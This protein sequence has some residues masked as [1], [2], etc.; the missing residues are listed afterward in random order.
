MTTETELKFQIPPAAL[1]AVRQAVAQH[2]RVQHTRL[3]ARYFDTPDG[4]LARA[5]VALRLRLEG[6]TWVQ[7]LK[8]PAAL[9]GA[10]GGLVSRLEHEVDL[11]PGDT[12]PTLDIS[13]H[14]DHPAGAALRAALHETGPPQRPAAALQV[15]FETDVQRSHGLL[16]HDGAQVEVALDEG[17]V[18]AGGRS[19]PLCELELELKQGDTAAL[20]ALAVPWVRAH[21]LWLDTRTKA[22]RGTLL[23]QA[24]AARPP[25]ARRRLAAQ[26]GAAAH[27]RWWGWWQVALASLLPQASAVAGGCGDRGHVLQLR[28]DL[29]RLLQCGAA[30]PSLAASR[31]CLLPVLRQVQH[32]CAPPDAGA[33]GGAG[34]ADGSH[35]E[36][37]ALGDVLRQPATT[38]LWLQLL[39]PPA[40]VDKA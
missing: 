8:A 31:P 40:R 25:R 29:L 1:A 30:A 4:R 15:T 38:V 13:R 3:R 20:L 12:P 28:R 16:A 35:L 17:C 14:D 36:L 18:M 9:A 5:G 10:A 33:A 37:A 32:D 27:P 7:T 34:L 24:R 21:G 22:E 19:L 23:A 39:A 2:S 26:P 11:G 6:A